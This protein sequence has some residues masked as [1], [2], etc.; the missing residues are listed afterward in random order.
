MSVPETG[1]RIVLK[2]MMERK[3]NIELHRELE[4][5]ELV[6]DK[7]KLGKKEA[8]KKKHSKNLK[9]N[10]Y[11]RGK[12]KQG[13]KIHMYHFVYEGLLSSAHSL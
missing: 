12:R 9:A 6:R 3:T 13:E 5:K 10:E 2:K 1:E 11:V 7:G 4:E 8:R